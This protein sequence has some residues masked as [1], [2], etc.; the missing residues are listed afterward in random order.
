MIRFENQIIDL[1][2]CLVGL[3]GVQIGFYMCLVGFCVCLV[4]L[5]GVYDR[6]LDVFG[7]L[8]CVF[9]WLVGC[10]D[11][12]L[13]VFGWLLCVYDWLVGCVRLAYGVVRGFNKSKTVYEH[14]FTN[15]FILCN[16]NNA[17][18]RFSIISMRIMRGI[19]VNQNIQEFTS[20]SLPVSLVVVL[21]PPVV[22]SL[23]PIFG[24]KSLVF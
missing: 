17:Q 7:W 1:W 5:W 18:T 22:S 3:W 11:W 12:L 2:G 9:G 24:G 19:R 6:L 15:R 13:D 14:T 4:G 8:L 20:S 21:L 16:T 10:A 23:R